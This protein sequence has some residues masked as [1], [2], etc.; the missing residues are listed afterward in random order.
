MADRVWMEGEQ[1]DVTWYA[2]EVAYPSKPPRLE[3]WP[4]E[5]WHPAEWY[6]RTGVSF[7]HWEIVEE[8]R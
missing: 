6:P 3:E 4:I 8:G 7:Q 1:V 2:S 5:T